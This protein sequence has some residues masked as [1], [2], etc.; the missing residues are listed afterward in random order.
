MIESVLSDHKE[1]IIL[2]KIID[3]VGDLSLSLPERSTA[4]ES[5][6]SVV[7][8]EIESGLLELERSEIGLEFNSHLL[9]VVNDAH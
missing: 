9:L 7:R 5:L 6:M 3:K 2:K 4:D 8:R 1:I